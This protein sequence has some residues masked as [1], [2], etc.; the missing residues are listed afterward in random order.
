MHISISAY[1][2]GAALL[3][4]QIGVPPSSGTSGNEGDRR[5]LFLSS[6]SP[7]SS[8]SLRRFE[9]ALRTRRTPSSPALRVSFVQTTPFDDQATE[10]AVRK[11]LNSPIALIIAASG[12]AARVARRVTNAMPLVFASFVDPVSAG[13][14]QSLQS[15]GKK[16]TGISLGDVLDAKRLE[17]LVEAFPKTR[18]IGVLADSSWISQPGSTERIAVAAARLGVGVRTFAANDVASV[19]AAFQ[20]RAARRIDAWYVP[21]TYLDRVAHLAII[22]ETKSRRKPVM[23]S[24]QFPMAAGATLAYSIEEAAVWSILA[25]LAIRIASGEDPSEIPVERPRRYMLSVRVNE[26]PEQPK[27]SEAVVRRADR[28]YWASH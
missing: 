9:E 19:K 16:A 10:L 11:A 12:D 20:H 4:A 15:P 18:R 25:D 13:L 28:V 8:E 26:A 5:V 21:S 3:A 1:A 2:A 6:S 7:Q 17:C 27:V 22:E 14:V 24:D 23:F